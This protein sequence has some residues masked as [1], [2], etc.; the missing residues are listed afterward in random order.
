MKNPATATINKAAE[1][2]RM[3]AMIVNFCLSSSS[4]SAVFFDCS[5]PVTI[6]TLLF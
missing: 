6:D 5:T 1:T 3:I 2:P 4:S